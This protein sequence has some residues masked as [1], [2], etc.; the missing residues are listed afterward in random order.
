MIRK[1]LISMLAGCASQAVFAQEVPS[2]VTA[3]GDAATEQTY[4]EE[5][6]V[7]GQRIT[8]REATV[9]VLGGLNILETPFA[10]R[11]VSRDF[12]DNV[13]ARSLS[14]SVKSDASVNFAAT[15][16]SYADGVQIRG[17]PANALVDNIYNE[18]QRQAFPTDIIERVEVLKG[19]TTFL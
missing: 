17:L 4:Q 8:D 6:T 3:G 7:T 18:S 11:A 5:I 12:I 15:T 10:I 9:G 16:G 19:T 13:F 1:L 2:G 14:E